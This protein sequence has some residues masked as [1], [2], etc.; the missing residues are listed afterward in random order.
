MKTSSLTSNGL[1]REE[2]IGHCFDS[3][4]RE[5]DSGKCVWQ[6]LENQSARQMWILFPK[7]CKVVA[8]AASDIHH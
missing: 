4:Q 8:L 6:V 1:G 2:I 5:I 3:L 7:A